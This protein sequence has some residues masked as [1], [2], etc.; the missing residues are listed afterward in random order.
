M[1]YRKIGLNYQH[2]SG[3]L[4][5][6]YRHALTSSKKVSK[7]GLRLGLGCL[8]SEGLHIFLVLLCNFPG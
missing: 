2:Q 5:A 3:S 7:D 6:G 1:L 4:L 8:R